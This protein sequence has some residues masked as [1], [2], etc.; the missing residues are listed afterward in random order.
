[1]TSARSAV[2]RNGSTLLQPQTHQPIS[3]ALTAARAMRT[4]GVAHQHHKPIRTHGFISA[5]HTFIVLHAPSPWLNSF[6]SNGPAE[7][8]ARDHRDRQMSRSTIGL[9]SPPLPTRWPVDQPWFSAALP[10]CCSY[11]IPLCQ[12]ET[13]LVFFSL[14]C[15]HL[16]C[17]F[18]DSACACTVNVV[19]SSNILW[20]GSQGRVSHGL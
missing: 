14:R 6:Q 2:C 17:D 13:G 9:R 10:P 18:S 7:C 15:L 20:I 12:G 19:H 16:P 4:G 1:M 11:L 8:I 3:D 5:D